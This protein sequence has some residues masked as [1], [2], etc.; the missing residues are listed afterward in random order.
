M[1]L[2]DGGCLAYYVRAGRGPC[3]VLIP[4]S[5]GEYTVFDRMVKTLNPD[6]RL[7]VVELRGHGRSWPPTLDASIELF[8]QDVLKVADALKLESF[9][10]GGHSIGGMIPIEIAKQRPDA[11]TGIIAIEGWTHHLVAKDAFDGIINILTPEQEKERSERMARVR[12][13]LTKEQ[14]DSFGSAWKHW[15]GLPILKTTST[16]VLE[17]WGDRGRPLPTRE[18]M[19]IPER[20]NIEIV[21]MSNASH[22]LLIERPG[23]VAEAINAF[24]A[25]VKA[26]GASSG[27]SQTRP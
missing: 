13:R 2:P 19:R 26:A 24:I 9:F 17:I 3:L 20:P 25:K 16:P 22:S 7:V 15:D 12:D 6:L 14:L 8:A 10:V 1:T 23:E 27:Q 21:W 18:A 5:W 4:G 11:V